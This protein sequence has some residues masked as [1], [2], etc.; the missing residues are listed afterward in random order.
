[1]SLMGTLA[2]V[3]VGVMVAKGVG[4]MVQ[5]GSAGAGR[6]ELP[7]SSGNGGLFDREPTKRS[8]TTPPP[9]GGTGG[10]EDLLGGI[11]GGGGAGGLGD[12]LGNVVSGQSKSGTGSGGGLG[13]L[14]E[15]LGGQKRPLPGGNS[16]KNDSFGD[17]LNSSFDR[18]GEPETPPTP[19]QD[20]V[21]GLLL[22]A[23]IQAAKADGKIDAGE[24]KKLIENLGDVD[25][26]EMDYVNAQLA[27]PVD[28]NALAR[29]V[30]SG[31]EAQ[32]YM[33][34]VM[35]IDLDERSEAQYLHS[36]AQALNISQAQSN[37]IHD[38]LG[39]PTIY[40]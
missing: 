24:K 15:Q 5:R 2:K 6:R 22:R 18:F 20:E 11:L 39:V 14:L 30:P 21:A 9:R 16:G 3:A 25:G 12:L 10:I 19:K 28:V 17:L 23:M 31:L 26:A 34:S 1:M 40:A 27:A 35:A 7:T 4:K 32:V 38:Q 8:T 33:M 37:Q 13:G 29:D 36:L